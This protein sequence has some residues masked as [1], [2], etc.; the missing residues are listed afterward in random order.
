V[1][2]RGGVQPSRER[3]GKLRLKNIEVNPLGVKLYSIRTFFLQKLTLSL[4]V[5]DFGTDEQG[6][7]NGTCSV[8]VLVGVGLLA[9]PLAFAYGGW[10]LGVLLL[11][12]CALVTN[13]TYSLLLARLSITDKGVQSS[14][15]G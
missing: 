2:D 12:F 4:N 5:E 7:A 11:L 15:Y 8:N 6:D 10:I 14:R 13:C 9:D 1:R 3:I